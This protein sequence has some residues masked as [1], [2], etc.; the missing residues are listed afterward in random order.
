MKDIDAHAGEGAP[1]FAG[2]APVEGG[3]VASLEGCDESIRLDGRADAAFPQETNAFQK[4]NVDGPAIARRHVAG[5]ALHVFAVQ[6]AIAVVVDAVVADLVG[7]DVRIGGRGVRKR[8]GLAV[9]GAEEEE[10]K[11]EGGGS[12]V[13]HGGP[14]GPPEGELLGIIH[15]TCWWLPPRRTIQARRAPAAER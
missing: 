3:D 5:N 4:G 8:P 6:R 13:G 2:D 7:D 11:K 15:S 9:A 14:L 10:K 1:V 12:W